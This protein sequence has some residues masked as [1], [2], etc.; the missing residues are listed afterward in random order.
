[1]F[2]LF[3]FF[4]MGSTSLKEIQFFN[5]KANFPKDS[6]KTMNTG[7]FVSVMLSAELVFL[8]FPF[9][10][11]PSTLSQGMGMDLRDL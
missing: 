11:N 2:C 10:F 6:C 5:Q 3:L 1:M 9:Q 4:L 7:W 8:W